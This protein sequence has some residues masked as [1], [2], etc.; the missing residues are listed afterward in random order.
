MKKTGET[1]DPVHWK[2]LGFLGPESSPL[3]IWR[4]GEPCDVDISEYT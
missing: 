3:K 4:I 2:I 1:V